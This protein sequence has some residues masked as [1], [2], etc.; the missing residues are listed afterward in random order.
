MAS[1]LTGRDGF[2]AAPLFVSDM[3]M[4]QLL[5]KLKHLYSGF[6]F[7]LLSL[8][9]ISLCL[10]IRSSFFLLSG[11]ISV[12][13]VID[14]LCKQPRIRE[15]WSTWRGGKESICNLQH[16]PPTSRHFVSRE[17][18]SSQITGWCL[19]QSPSLSSPCFHDNDMTCLAPQKQG[20]ETNPSFLTAPKCLLSHPQQ[21]SH[22]QTQ[23]SEG[24]A[25][26]KHRHLPP[27]PRHCWLYFHCKHQSR[28]CPLWRTWDTALISS[29]LEDTCHTDTVVD[30]EDFF[31]LFWFFIPGES[32]V[33]VSLL[34]HHRNDSSSR[35]SEG[36]DEQVE[37]HVQL[38]H[39]QITAHIT[40]LCWKMHSETSS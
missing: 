25:T 36:A 24:P 34:S 40:P 38:Q 21:F 15:K 5:H 28:L 22:R 20:G 3:Q 10:G 11:C 12:S 8:H 37:S 16:H 31:V 1:L 23:Q 6:F 14:F 39:K 9:W 19:Q 33:Y 32:E 26:T 17:N 27:P 7:R 13:V 18:G 2:I 29:A 30:L 4:K 35:S